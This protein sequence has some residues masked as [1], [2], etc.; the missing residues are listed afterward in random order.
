M[1][2]EKALT[3]ILIG[4]V[5]GTLAGLT[6]IGGGVFLVPLL[7]A[8]LYVSQYEAH[9][10]SLAVIFPM[11]LCSAV[12]Y[13]V[14]GYIRWDVFLTLAAGGVVGA[15]LGARLMKRVSE[16]H[17]Q[18]LFGLFVV[19]VG[20]VM[21][22]TNSTVAVPVKERDLGVLAYFGF[23]GG[24]VLAG[25]LSGVMGVGGGVVLIPIMV[26]LVGMDQHSAQGI[27]LA[28]IAVISFFGAFSHFRQKNVRNDIA[29]YVAPSALVYGLFGSFLADRIDANILRAVVGGIIIMAGVLTIFRNWRSGGFAS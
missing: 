29:M 20:F 15:L 19:C 10:T 23:V 2:R 8:V 26:L 24:G 7:V 6:G 13:G 4:A 22:T 5:V 28:A 9:G 3:C 11:A 17:L 18:W 12:V 14:M 25:I 16:R 21:I 27:S 1:S